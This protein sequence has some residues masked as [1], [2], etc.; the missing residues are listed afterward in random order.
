VLA[1][2]VVQLWVVLGS[3]TEQVIAA[4][5]VHQLQVVVISALAV[6][7]LQG[8]WTAAPSVRPLLVVLHFGIEQVIAALAVQLL[9]VVLHFGIEQVIAALAV[10][11]LLVVRD[12]WT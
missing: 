7:Q 5:A 11:L 8:S 12:P 10:Q 3:W 2:F 1:G 4:L 6:H 9:L